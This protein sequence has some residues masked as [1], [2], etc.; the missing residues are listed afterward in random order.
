MFAARFLTHRSASK[1]VSAAGIGGYVVFHDGRLRSNFS[2]LAEPSSPQFPAERF[3]TPSMDKLFPVIEATLRV[4]RLVKTAALM[5][6][7]YQMADWLD[8]EPQDSAAQYWER[9]VERRKKVLDDAQTTYT[10]QTHPE[11]DNYARFLAKS[12]EKRAMEK[13]AEE[14]TYAQEQL[15]KHPS[16]TSRIHRKAAN[17][18]LQLCHDNRG[19]YIKVGQ[20]IANLDY[21]VPHEY[22]QVLSALFDNNPRTTYADVR[23][24]IQQDFGKDPSELWDHFEPEPIASASLA[25]VHVAY[26]KVTGE[27]IAVKVQHYGLRETCAGDLFALVNIVRLAERL[28]EGFTWGWLADEIAPQLPKELDFQ[29]EG[30]NAERAASNLENAGI[31]AC[32]VPKIIWEQSSPRVLTMQFEEGFKATDVE[33]IRRAGLHERDVARLISSVFS[34]QV[35][36]SGWVHCD[37]HPANVLL[38]ANEGKPEIILLDHGLYRELDHEFRLKYAYLWRSL[39]LADLDAIKGACSSLG[40]DRAYA[41]FAAMLTARPFDEMIERSKSRAL[42]HGAQVGNRADQAVIR[43]YAQRYLN[44]IFDLLGSLPRQMLLLLKMND[45]LR[46]IDYSLGS[47]TNTIVISGSYAARAVFESIWSNAKSSW[48][49]RCHAWWDYF[50]IAVWVRLHDAATVWLS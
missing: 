30:R 32:V 9:E 39:M 13:A 41:L 44:E 14:L 6:A 24:I 8:T 18:L 48:T 33:A 26:D 31:T 40:V 47:P 23:R 20:H 17:R 37:P 25:Q 5:A 19:V 15:E 38:R 27:K 42:S 49:S 10:Q 22:I 28:F 3:S 4:V 7:D 11:L 45:C 34:S 1:L 50:R 12:H 35:F 29:N 36:L 43:N 16:R 21:L 46:H 2:T